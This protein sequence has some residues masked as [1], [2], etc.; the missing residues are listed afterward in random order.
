M[1]SIMRIR[2]L[3]TV[4][5]SCLLVSCNRNLKGYREVMNY[6]NDPENELKK[7]EQAGRIEV[8]ATFLPVQIVGLNDQRLTRDNSNK[9]LFSISFSAHGKELLK[10]LD[11]QKYSAMVEVFAFRMSNY[12][13]I[14]PDNLKPVAP[15]D[16]LFQQT[17]GM[18]DA[19]RILVAFDKKELSQKE[20]LH[21]VIKE[22]GLGTGDISFDF[23][24]SDIENIPHITL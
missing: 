5:V 22:L 11:Y 24:S 2:I 18:S 16:C 4:L 7:E 8:T 23:R 13:E 9:Y 20:K 17:Y 1:K 19:N 6:I 21:L 10:Q 12:V 15:V 3:L 14:V